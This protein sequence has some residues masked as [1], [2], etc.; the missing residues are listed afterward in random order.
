[1]VAGYAGGQTALLLKGAYVVRKRK[2][3]TSISEEEY[4]GELLREA[5]YELS[6]KITD[7]QANKILA[8]VLKKIRGETI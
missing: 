1:M 7:E 2:Q 4:L 8:P 5:L 6:E 3:A